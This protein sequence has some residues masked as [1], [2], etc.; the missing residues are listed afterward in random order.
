METLRREDM[1]LFVLT[2]KW[3]WKR[4]NGVLHG[5]RFTHPC[6]VSKE[7]M[8]DLLQYQRANDKHQVVSTVLQVNA[9]KWEAPPSGIFKVNWDDAIAQQEERMGV[10]VVIRDEKG[11]VIAALCKLVDGHFDPVTADAAAA[12]STVEFCLEVGVQDILLEGDS[13]TVVEA[14]RN[15]SP[16]WFHYGQIIDDIKIVLGSLR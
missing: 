14:V 3:I 8:D 10:G 5:D 15:Q 4:R 11:T 16:N 2:A 1:E 9:Q 13:A 6:V 12:L 7:A